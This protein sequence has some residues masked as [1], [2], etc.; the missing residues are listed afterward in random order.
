MERTEIIHILGA[1][2]ILS[3]AFGW[4]WKGMFAHPYPA[5]FIFSFITAII[6][7]GSGFILHEL[8]HKYVAIRYHARAEFRASPVGLLIGLLFAIFNSPIIFALPGAVLIV[9]NEIDTRKNGIISVVGPLVNISLSILFLV[10]AIILST[11]SQPEIAT[12]AFISSY[13]N[14]ILA[15][16]NLIP[17]WELDGAKVLRWNRLLWASLFVPLALIY[18][19]IKF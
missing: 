8:A 10:L 1:T 19:V 6:A 9:G 17:V 12:I 2:F 5:N 3:V 11:I 14:F 18:L 7:V 13:I 15:L 4:A 16:F